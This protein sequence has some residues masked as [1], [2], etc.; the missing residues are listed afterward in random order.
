MSPAFYLLAQKLVPHIPCVDQF[1]SA[2]YRVHCVGIL[3]GS[4]QVDLFTHHG[5][6]PGDRGPVRWFTFQIWCLGAILRSNYHDGSSRGL[7]DRYSGVHVLRTLQVQ[8]ARKRIVL[9]L[10]LA[11][12]VPTDV[13]CTR[14]TTNMTAVCHILVHPECSVQGN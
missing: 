2:L 1:R 14:S 7:K 12:G 4:C 10:V 3:S 5:D 13:P 8:D 9:L 11:Y 6:C